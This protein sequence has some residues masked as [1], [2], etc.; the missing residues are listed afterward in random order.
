MSGIRSWFAGPSRDD[1]DYVPRVDTRFDLRF[2][3]L[4]IAD[5]LLVQC[6]KGTYKGCPEFRSNFAVKMFAKSVEGM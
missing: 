2:F 5:H 1:S 6:N 3:T 4:A